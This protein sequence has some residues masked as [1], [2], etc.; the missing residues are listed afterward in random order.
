VTVRRSRVLLT[1]SP[2]YIWYHSG[3]C[4]LTPDFC[5]IICA[6]TCKI[7]EYFQIFSNVSHQ[8]SNIFKRFAP[9][10]KYFQMFS[11]VLALSLSKGSNVSSTNSCL[12]GALA[13]ADAHLMRHLR[14]H[15][16]TSGARCRLGRFGCVLALPASPVRQAGAFPPACLA[17]ELPPNCCLSS[18]YL[19]LINTAFL[20]AISIGASKKMV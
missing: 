11:I 6:S 17:D 4:I 5:S 19:Q 16:R 14:C 9:L 3:L 10:F 7:L 1:D 2:T 18:L 12:A 15:Y 8:F 20:F 13:K